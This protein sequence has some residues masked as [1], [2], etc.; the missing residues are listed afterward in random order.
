MTCKQSRLGSITCSIGGTNRCSTEASAQAGL[1]EEARP[2]RGAL[3]V[4]LVLRL[5][6]DVS[7]AKADSLCNGITDGSFT[8]QNHIEVGTINAVV[9]CK[10]ALTSFSL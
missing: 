10:S 4:R 9:L 1:M 8:V 7:L 5:L 2:S 3:R 6:S